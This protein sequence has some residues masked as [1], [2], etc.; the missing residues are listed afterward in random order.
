MDEVVKLSSPAIRSL[1]ESSNS[2]RISGGPIKNATIL[3]ERGSASG[4][5]KIF[6]RVPTRLG[7]LK[8]KSPN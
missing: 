7:H 8:M 5:S 6:G 4:Q 2:I 1:S 3:E